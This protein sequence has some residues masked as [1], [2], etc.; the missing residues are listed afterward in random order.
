MKYIT[1]ICGLKI[2]DLNMIGNFSG[3]PHEKL[4]YKKKN[5]DWRKKHLDWADSYIWSYDSRVRK[6]LKNKIINTNLMNGILDISDMELI[7][8]PNQVD[9]AFI[10]DNIQHYP[11]IN[12]KLNLLAGE[13]SKRRFDYKLV[14]TNMDEISEIE[15]NKKER[16]LAE[17]QQWAT[18]DAQSEEEA[19]QSLEKIDKYM[20]Y[21]WQDVREIRGNAVLSHYKK[22]LSMPLKFNSGFYWAMTNGEEAYQCDI[23][24]GEPTMELINPN[25]MI[26]LKS[27]F[28]N[29]L[30]DADM[31]VLWDFWSP[32]KVIDTYY[33]V[34]T[35]EDMKYI[36]ELPFAVNVDSQTE[37]IDPRAGFTFVNPINSDGTTEFDEGAVVEGLFR[38]NNILFDTNYTDNFGNVRVIRVYW[39]SYRKILKV[40]SY[41]VE[42]GEEEYSFYPE[43]YI[44]NELL[45]EEAEPLW[46]NEAWEGTKIGKNIYVNMRPRICQYNRISNPSR[47]HFGIIGS[48]YSNNEGRPYSLVDMCKPYNYLYNVVHDRLNKNLA[49]NWGKIASLDLAQV[50]DNWDIDK[51]MYYARIHKL[52]VK[53]S[54]KEGNKGQATGRLAGMMNNQSSGVID[55]N[56]GDIIQHDINLL[57]FIKMEMS[58]I[59]GITQQREGQISNRETVGGVERSVLQSSHITEWLFTIHEDIKKRVLECFLETAKA[60]MRGRTLKFQYLLS[61]GSLKMIE[62]DG[63]EFYECDYGLVCDNSDD[64]DNFI[65]KMEMYAQALI[66]NQ[67]ISTSSLIKLW[68]GSSIADI[69]RSIEA[70]ER[71]IKEQR[72][73]EQQQNQQQFEADLQAR[74]ELEQQKLAIDEGKNVRDNETKVL[75]EQMRQGA[76]A[77]VEDVNQE[78]EY[79]PQEKEKLLEN[80]RQFNEKLSLEK[81]KLSFTKEKGRKE[82]DL[83][84]KQIAV[85]KMNKQQSSTKK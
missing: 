28:S 17:L 7:L 51:W 39:K 22:E 23:V 19:M 65:Q 15:N 37:A 34:L 59:A 64:I 42:T 33:D 75:I 49:A 41:D 48:I 66:Q 8:N 61:D 36:D 25:K 60:A 73:Q 74:Q 29:R 24:G 68:N 12:G 53:D 52:A 46:I 5:K 56:Q 10:P 84:E 9:A 54:F 63:D 62:I 35:D 32:A 4:S 40:K 38:A 13:E 50:P 26:V 6:S 79:S 78:E 72:M 14:V 27:G 67:M 82:L 44:P 55:A 45:G 58:E 57:Q 2:N 3:L 70:D 71:D 81:D 18:Q 16:W 43:T 31:I 80:I 83:K 76:N 69:T 1:Y 11:I 77:E 21:E 30:E 47:C 20:K 85:Q